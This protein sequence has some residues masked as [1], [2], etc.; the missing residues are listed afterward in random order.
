MRILIHGGTV[1]TFGSPC[2]VLEGRAVLIEDGRIARIAPKEAIPGPF[3]RTLD[4]TGKVVMPGLVNAHMHFYSTL[5]RG[6]GKAAPSAN[7]QEVLDNLWW[8]LDRKLS[9][10][11]VD[12]SAEVVLADAVRKGTTTLVDHHASPFAAAGS[13]DRIAGAVRRSGVRACLC[14]EV[15]DRDGQAVTDA[16]LEE[17]AAFARRCASEKD[18]HLRALFGLH[19]A[20]TLTDATLDRAA[21]LGR[22]A[23]VGFHVHVAEAASDVAYNLQHHGLTSVAR[24]AGHGLLGRGSIA[25]HCVHASEADQE[26]LAST[27]TFVAHNPQSNLNNAV[28]I[29]DVLGMVRR[30][31]RV[32]LGTDAMT[33]NMLEEIRVAMWA[34]HLRQDNPT[35]A[36]MEIA[37]TLF[38]RNPELATQLWG[39]PLG[40]LEEGAAADVILVDYHP[41]TPLD[42]NTV[43]GHLVFGISQ[44]TVDT[45]LCAG[46]I[47]MEGKVLCNGLDEAALAARSRELAVKLWDRF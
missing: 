6:L 15:S 46:R 45:T 1:I 11:D 9:L 38:A 5:V 28:G 40:T 14:Y 33:V 16:G 42:G 20:F 41:P 30:G 37:N 32:G 17:N 2:R 27:D 21:V 44:A 18:P 35:C 8:R 19:A 13:L 31:V 23:G 39:F 34:Q 47:L 29:A 26:L 3:D 4:A 43:L 25:A 7:F 12:I 22:D 36:F 24:L 10:D